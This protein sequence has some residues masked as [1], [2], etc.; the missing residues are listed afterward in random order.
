MEKEKQITVLQKDI[1]SLRE[2]LEFDAN[3]KEIMFEEAHEKESAI[4]KYKQDVEQYKTDID[5]L[6]SELQQA[7]F[8]GATADQVKVIE[9][10][11]KDLQSYE[12]TT[13]EAKHRYND[14]SQKLSVALEERNEFEKTSE[15]QSSKIARLQSDLDS[16]M[17][18]SAVSGKSTFKTHELNRSVVAESPENVLS[19]AEVEELQSEM[20]QITE[21]LE[22]LQQELDT[23]TAENENLM[24]QLT[25]EKV[26]NDIQSQAN[27]S[28]D[29]EVSEL[30]E[31][32][33]NAQTILNQLQQEKDQL[34]HSETLLKDCA[35]QNKSEVSK[36]Q[37]LLEEREN[38][39][40][41][42]NEELQQICKEKESMESA[43]EKMREDNQVMQNLVDTQNDKEEEEKLNS[44]LLT[45]D[46]AIGE[47]EKQI[48]ALEEQ[49]K[50]LT[51]E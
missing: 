14:A 2:H 38:N 34:V 12:E 6:Q 37:E 10:L 51:D 16:Y 50:L 24:L 27:A 26:E 5:K 29:K 3:E 4:E 17:A 9:N 19:K 20:A 23:K 18:M 7:Q 41:S 8:A 13:R 1:S 47:K 25:D 39:I 11:Q 28:K 46:V 22:L 43:I 21:K 33:D 36:L 32:L 40:Q 44:Q 30:K 31:E 15:L 48:S 35:E 42:L 45:M 49:I